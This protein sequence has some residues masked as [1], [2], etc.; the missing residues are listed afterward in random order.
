MIEKVELSTVI[1]FIISLFLFLSAGF[2]GEFNSILEHLE[3]IRGEEMTY[4]SFQ[5]ILRFLTLPSEGM[6]LTILLP[7]L[8]VIFK[9][10]TFQE[11]RSACFI[12]V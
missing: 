12:I 8:V 6:S 9:V 4:L 7:G 2:V 10:E 1:N 3:N 11:F 5:F